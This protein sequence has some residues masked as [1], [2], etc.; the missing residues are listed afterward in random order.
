[1]SFLVRFRGRIRMSLCRRAGRPA[2]FRRSDRFAREVPS[3]VQ[4]RVG[5]ASP[6]IC[7]L[8]PREREMSGSQSLRFVPSMEAL[9]DRFAPSA[10]GGANE[11]VYGNE[12]PDANREVRHRMFAIVDRTQMSDG[13]VVLYSRCRWRRVVKMRGGESR[14]FAGSHALRVTR[15]ASDLL[16]VP[17]TRLSSPPAPSPSASPASPS[18]RSGR[19]CSSSPTRGPCPRRAAS[20]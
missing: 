15:G 10:V 7:D 20:R 2:A 17:F 3:L 1:M 14:R 13:V 12:L 11:W 8:R 5:G 9:D 16:S 4:A 19:R 18:D 6:R